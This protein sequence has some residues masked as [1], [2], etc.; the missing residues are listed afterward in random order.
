MF[1]SRE[2]NSRHCLMVALCFLEIINSGLCLKLSEAVGV[3]Y[4][5]LI[6]GRNEAGQMVVKVTDDIALNLEKSSVVGEEFLLRTYQG[7]IMEHNYLDGHLLEENLY[8]DIKF[9][10]S[11]IVTQSNGLKVEGGTFHTSF[12]ELPRDKYQMNTVRRPASTFV[13]PRQNANQWPPRQIVVELLVIADSAFRK[14]FRTKEDLLQY[15]LITLNSVNLKYLTVAE[16]E[17]RI[18]FCALEV[19]NHNVENE[20]YASHILEAFVRPR[21]VGIGEDKEGT[22]RGVRVISHELGHLLG[23][24]HDSERYPGFSSWDCPW[25]D[26]FMMTY[27]TNSS[28]SMKF[29]KCCDEAITKLVTTTRRVCLVQQTGIRNIKK[30]SLTHKLPGEV[31]NRNQVCQISFP[32]VKDIRFATVNILFAQ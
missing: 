28:N 9:F 12:Y 13:S 32:D 2:F 11:L 5:Q 4:P 1:T 6:E 27:L 8:H 14:Q 7:D 17:V 3:V 21:K 30:T 29:S 26:G 10:A 20:F 15:L 25:Y 19:I 22:Y 31:L 16:P 23:C 24:P 18:N